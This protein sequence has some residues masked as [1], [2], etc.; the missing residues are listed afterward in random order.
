MRK[1]EFAEFFV[2]AFAFYYTTLIRDHRRRHWYW[3]AWYLMK[4]TLARG[5]GGLSGGGG[6]KQAARPEPVPPAKANA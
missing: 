5:T 3:R 2:A 1:I 4:E 6:D